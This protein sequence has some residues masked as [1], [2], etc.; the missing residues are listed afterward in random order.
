[1]TIYQ[2]DAVVGG[3]M[4]DYAMAGVVLCR[5]AQYTCTAD[6]AT[7][8]TIQM[9]PVPANCRILDIHMAVNTPGS[10]GHLSVG[11]GSSVSRFFNGLTNSTTSQ[12]T[13]M[14][15]SNAVQGAMWQSYTSSDT[16]DVTV[17]TSNLASGCV[18]TMHVYYKMTGTLEDET[19]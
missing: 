10:D 3:V 8:D 7:L 14:S 17:E 11:D 9:V 16:I 13:F 4:P 18:L 19:P 5:S 15:S 1:M 2:S 12:E 6:I